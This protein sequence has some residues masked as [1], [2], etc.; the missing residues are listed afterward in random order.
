LYAGSLSTSNNWLLYNNGI[1]ILLVEKTQIEQ[2][3]ITIQSI[4]LKTIAYIQL[5]ADYFCTVGL[6]I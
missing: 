2:L 1:V 6:Y 3:I 5:T 4:Q